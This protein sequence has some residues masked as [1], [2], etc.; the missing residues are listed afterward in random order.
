MM[1]LLSYPNQNDEYH[2][3]LM[4]RHKKVMGNG[5]NDVPVGWR[6]LSDKEFARSGF[7]QENWLGTDFKQFKVEPE[8]KAVS[9]VHLFIANDFTGYAIVNDYWAET[10]RYF[11]FGCEH[12]MRE[13][14]QAESRQRG[15]PHYGRCYHNMECT[16]C[17]IVKSYDSS[18]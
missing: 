10:I 1:R 7:F 9:G 8:D 4:E 17:G 6:R 12:K 13:L 3:K 15:I 16:L 11:R 2:Q 5:H 18:D 14:S